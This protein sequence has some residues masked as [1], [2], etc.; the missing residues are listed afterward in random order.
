MKAIFLLLF[1]YYWSRTSKGSETTTYSRPIAYS[2][3]SWN[4]ISAMCS[5]SFI[6]WKV[7][8][9]SGGLQ[10]TNL[11]LLYVIG[12]TM[13]FEHFG[14]AEAREIHGQAL[15]SGGSIS[16]A[17]RWIDEKILRPIRTFHQKFSHD[18]QMPCRFTYNLKNFFHVISSAKGCLSFQSHRLRRNRLH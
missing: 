15:T 3:P 7:H 14:S 16:Q 1:P 17:R 9:S 8:D 12:A 18:Q 11:L 5:S 2:F 13:H 4:L 10:N 6:C